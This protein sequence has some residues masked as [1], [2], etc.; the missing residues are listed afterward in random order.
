MRSRNAVPFRPA[1]FDVWDDH[2]YY[3]TTT[4]PVVGMYVPPEGVR[5]PAENNPRV[6]AL[7][8]RDLPLEFIRQYIFSLSA[9]SPPICFQQNGGQ[10]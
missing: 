1:D 3:L 5:C 10:F 6:R 7:P 9:H 2:S 4:L 8:E